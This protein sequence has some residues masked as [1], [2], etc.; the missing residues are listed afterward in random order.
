MKMPNTPASPGTIT[1][2]GVFTSPRPFTMRNNGI[3]P[4]CAG[5]TMAATSTRN[6]ASRPR[7]RS[8]AN[9]YPAMEFTTSENSVTLTVTKS[10]FANVRARLSR[11]KRST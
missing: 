9:A 8:F 2:H 5:I 6:T 11:V 10:E 4:T 7:K 3:M 1:P